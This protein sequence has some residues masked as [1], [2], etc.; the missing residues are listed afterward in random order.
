MIAEAHEQ[1]L[2]VRK[3]TA[4]A[5]LELPVVVRA[6]LLPAQILIDFERVSGI[7]P[8]GQKIRTITVIP[9]KVIDGE[10]DEHKNRAV[11][12]LL[13]DDAGSVVVVEAIGIR[14]SA[15]QLLGVEE[16]LD[17]RSGLEAA[18]A[19]KPAE[20][21]IEAVGFV[22]A[23]A[24]GMGQAAL[25]PPGGQPGDGVREAAVGAHGQSGEHVV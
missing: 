12:A 2:L 13:R 21:R 17:P 5:L 22:A 20:P 24:Q 9:G 10:I 8:A 7:D 4:K 18:G 16:M 1:E 11:V 25:D 19:D 15:A 14:R 6:Q 3:L 23:L